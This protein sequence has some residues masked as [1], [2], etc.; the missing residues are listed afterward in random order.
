MLQYLTKYVYFHSSKYAN[1]TLDSKI[2]LVNF[3]MG[4]HT[5]RMRTK[6]CRIFI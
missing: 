3:E 6:K 1:R 2:Y 4:K 5:Y